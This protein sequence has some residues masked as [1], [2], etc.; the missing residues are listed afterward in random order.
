MTSAAELNREAELLIGRLKWVSS[1]TRLESAMGEYALH[2]KR[3]HSE[4]QPRV[5]AGNWDGG[6]W[7]SVGGSGDRVRTA[8]AGNLISQRVG[9]GDSGLIRQCIYV[10]MLGRQF[11]FEQDAS[12]LCP[13][14]YVA[15][16]A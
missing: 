13:R 2:L 11:G 9:V 5:P 15:P 14:T 8:L 6:R 3:H 1:A 12:R 4:D 16:P 10:D 7:T